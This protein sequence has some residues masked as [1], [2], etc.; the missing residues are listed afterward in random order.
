MIRMELTFIAR[1]ER[2]PNVVGV[3]CLVYTPV[4]HRPYRLITSEDVCLATDATYWAIVPP[5]IKD[6]IVKECGI[7]GDK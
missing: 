3:P 7:E 4:D 5:L 1:A 2:L 6:E